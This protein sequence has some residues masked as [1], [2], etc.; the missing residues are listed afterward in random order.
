MKRIVICMSIV[1]CT[2]FVFAA[3]KSGC[4]SCAKAAK[5]KNS[6]A[7]TDESGQADNGTLKASKKLRKW[8]IE[9]QS[10][11]VSAAIDV[12]KKRS[13]PKYTKKAWI[14]NRRDGTKS[15]LVE[16]TTDKKN[17]TIVFSPDESFAYYLGLSANGESIVYGV[18]LSS[19][20][21]FEI[22]YGSTFDTLT[23]PDK[24]NY[25]IV[26]DSSGKKIYHVYDALGTKINSIN[27]IRGIESVNRYV[28]Y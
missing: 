25:V 18:N 26:Q 21:Q 2:N 4:S 28:C 24:T 9:S 15:V 16:Y 7:F 8:N 14:V 1:L 6:S 27:Q 10:D 11:N 13:N 5:T 20:Q 17:D 12:Y 19:N 23:C 22:G 3:E